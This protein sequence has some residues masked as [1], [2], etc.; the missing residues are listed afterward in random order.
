MWQRQNDFSTATKRIT[1]ASFVIGF[2]L[3]VSGCHVFSRNRGIVESVYHTGQPVDFFVS[4]HFFSLR[5]GRLVMLLPRMRDNNYEAQARF[6]D[7]LAQALTQAGVFEIVL[8]TGVCDQSMDTIRNGTFDERALL[9]T[10][11]RHN[12]DGVLFC[13]VTT[14]SPYE[15]LHL[16]CALT[17]VDTRESIVT[18]HTNGVWNSTDENVAAKFQQDVCRVHHCKSYAAAVYLKSPSEFMKFVARDLTSFVQS[19]VY[20]GLEDGQTIHYPAVGQ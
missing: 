4:P 1:V 11:R 9:E 14:F 19:S 8:Q 13:E 7:S 17:L 3:A 2:A 10:A 15:P 6:A 16:G 5:P 12:A 20:Q 18:L